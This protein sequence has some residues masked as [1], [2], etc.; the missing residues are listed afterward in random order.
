MYYKL[1]Y[2][3]IKLSGCL[4]VYISCMWWIDENIYI[5]YVHIAMTVWNL[6]IYNH[7]TRTNNS[8][9]YIYDNAET[10]PK[11]QPVLKYHMCSN[12]LLSWW[13]HQMETF[14]ALLALC[15]GNSPVTGNSPLKGQ[16]RGASMFSLTRPWTNGWANHRHTGDLRRNRVQSDVAIMLLAIHVIIKQCRG[17]F[18]VL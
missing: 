13:R 3:I 14:S 1:D 11:Q 6:S 17:I 2:K 7:R 10:P 12:L 5:I 9:W 15:E 4:H 18:I 8:I 16:W